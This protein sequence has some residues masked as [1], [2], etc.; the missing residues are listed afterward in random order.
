MDLQNSITV[1]PGIGPSFAKRLEKL[2]ISTIEDFLLYIPF[3]YQDLSIISNISAVQ[4]GEEVTIK[5]KVEKFQNIYTRFHK[6]F[7]IATI[8][9]TTG[10]IQ[11]VWF[12]QPFL[13]N[14]F[15]KG[16]KF[17][18]AGK[19]NSWNKK[20]A[21]IS[22][23]Y[24]RLPE[25]G[26]TLH[27]GRLVPVYSETKGISSK[28]L[29]AKISDLL[30]ILENEITEFLPDKVL[31][32]HKLIHFNEAIN[33]IHFPN[34]FNEVYISKNRLAFNELLFI[35]LSSLERRKK[36]LEDKK[37][38]AQPIKNQLLDEFISGLP[39]E[40]TP[41]QVRSIAE[42]R[43]SMS[44]KIPMN[45]LLEGDVGSGKTLVA[46]A[47]AFVAFASRMQSIVM[48]PTQILAEQHFK[49]L[50]Q[51]LEKY[52]VR[53][54]LV[55]SGQK[56]LEIGQSDIFVGTHA[57]LERKADFKKVGFVVI[58]EQHRFGVAQRELLIKIS[59]KRKIVP[60]VLTMTATP[61]PRTI[62]LTVY[63]DLD[64]STLDELPKGRIPISTWVVPEAKR[65]GAYEWIIKEIEQNK[66]QAFIVCPL[67]EESEKESMQNVKAVKQE[68]ERLKKIFSQYKLGLLHGRLKSAE[69][70]QVLNDFK[71]GK[72]EILVSTPVVEVG[73]D[74]PNATIMVIEA[75]ERFGLAQLHQ[76]RGRIGRGNRKSYCL[77]FSDNSTE[78]T[79][80]RLEAVKKYRSGHELAEVDLKL[81]GPGE[82]FGVKQHGYAD[83]KIA[84]WQDIGLIRETKELANK[85]VKDWGN[86]PTLQ[87]KF[88]EKKVVSY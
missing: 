49:T 8:S 77:L 1:L 5:G 33:K 30:K 31:L 52:K 42:I 4:P 15:G 47:G 34:N 57:L 36:W 81:R 70:S 39:F 16:G 14:I 18:F 37:S 62:A 46:A 38:I 75:A 59:G 6:N 73:V 68:F 76:L 43:E 28:W 85:I 41:S 69:K 56:K 27:T 22:P 72:Y 26:S 2:G 45:R 55:T 51:I 88:A 84:S 20:T 24:E 79:I 11:A 64:L 44:Q 54:A 61:I 82:I 40:L 86:S 74:I 80:G 66:T 78:K 32:D 9:D 29:R 50:N 12:N 83:L 87:K 58:D 7:Q 23:E 17:S 67:I 3:R 21:L 48:A 53:V 19:I 25:D 71:E 60:H 10:N 65:G 63:G 13:A 35:H